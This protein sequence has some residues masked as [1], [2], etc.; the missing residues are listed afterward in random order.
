MAK[1]GSRGTD[2][3]NMEK[4]WQRIDLGLKGKEYEHEL[5]KEIRENLRR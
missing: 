3:K 4:I 2:F 5:P 1:R